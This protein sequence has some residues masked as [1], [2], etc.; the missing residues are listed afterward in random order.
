MGL[1]VYGRKQANWLPLQNP[2]LLCISRRAGVV[3]GRLIPGTSKHHADIWADVL[4]TIER[5]I[6]V[7]GMQWE[8]PLNQLD[9]LGPA[10]WSQITEA[11]QGIREI[12]D[13]TLCDILDQ[14]S[15]IRPDKIAVEAWD[16]NLTYGELHGLS[17]HMATLLIKKGAIQEDR[18]GFSMKKSKWAMVT[19]WAILMAGCTVVPLDIRNPLKRTRELV[20]RTAARYVVADQW[21][22]PGLESVDATII[23]CQTDTLDTI[24]GNETGLDIVWPQV[25]TRSVAYILFTSGSTGIPKGVVLEHGPLYAS[26]VEFAAEYEMSENSTTFQFAPFV[27][28]A[29]TGEIFTTM[30]QGGCL[31]VPSE[32]ERLDNLSGTLRRSRAT[33]IGLPSSIMAQ[34][35]TDDATHLEYL[36]AVGEILSRANFLKWSPRV[37]VV[38]GYGITETIIFDSF[39]RSQHLSSDHRNIGLANGR[40]WITDEDDP[41]KLMP[42]GAIG[43]I[44]IEGP[45]LARGYLDD[46]KRTA[47]RFILAPP[48]LQT[49]RGGVENHRCYRSGDYGIRNADGTVLYMGRMDFQVK[50]GGQRVELGE[51]EHNLLGM[52]PALGQVA[53]EAVQLEHRGNTQAVVA[54]V[55][56]TSTDSKDPSAMLPMDDDLK[57]IFQTAQSKLL[58]IL[59]RHMVPRLFIPIR[60]IPK[61]AVGKRD[62]KCLRSWGAS[63]T[64]EQLAQYQLQDSS[65]YQSPDTPEERLLHELWA[66][67]L[68]APSDSLSLNDNFFQIGGDSIKAIE[69]VAE[70]RKQRRGLTVSHIFQNPVMGEMAELLSLVREDGPG[71]VSRPFDLIP[72]SLTKDIAVQEVVQVCQVN[73]EQI[74]DIYPAAP[75]QEA[76]MAI[77]ASRPTSFYKHRLVFIMPESIDVDRFKEAWE[78]LISAQP[79]LRT[80]IVTMA[81]AGT[82]QVVVRAHV[83]WQSDKSLNELL[84]W[85]DETP[86]TYGSALSRYAIVRDETHRW[87]FIWSG[88]HAITDGWSRPAMFDAVRHIYNHGSVP[89]QTPYTPFIKYIS[90]LN[91]EESDEFWR[92]QF[93]DIV[94]SFPR[95]CSPDFIPHAQHMQALA[96]TLG[97]PATCKTTPATLVQAAWS[98]VT[99]AYA[100]TNEAVFGLTLSG[101]DAPVPDITKMMGIT[102][103]TVPVRVAFD[104][105]STIAEY[106]EEVQSYIS[107]VKQHQH[108]GLQRISHLSPEARS[109]TGFQNLLVIQPADEDE[110]H[111]GLA[112]LGL[113]LIQREEKDKEDHALTIQCTLNKNG[114]SLKVKAYYDD[115]VV[116]TEEVDCLL[117]LFE[118]IVKQLA[119]EST[120]HSLHDFDRLSPHDLNILAKHNSQAPPAIEQTLHSLFEERARETPMGIALDGFGGTMTYSELDL[121]SSKLASH[122]RRHT[123]VTVESRVLL[124]FRKSQLP[125]IA[126][127]AIL[128]CGGV[129]VSTDPGHPTARL[130][131]ISKDVESKI[132]LC[133]ESNVEIFGGGDVPVIGLTDALLGKLVSESAFI[134]SDYPHPKV[135][136]SNAS[137]IVYTS[138]S[139]GKPKGSVLEHR[140]LVTEFIALGQRAGLSARSR[141]LQFSAYTFDVHIVEIF[142]TLIHGGCVCVISDYERMNRLE[143]VINERR[144]NFAVLTKTVSRLLEPHNVPT[145]EALI[146]TGEANRRQDYWRWAER[147]RLFNGLGPSECTPLVCLTRNPVG[148]ETDPANIGNALACRLWVTDHRRPDRL[149]PIGCV[150]ELTVEGPIVG[151]G[152]VN[153]PRETASAFI[154]DPA[155]ARNENGS[156]APRRFYRSGDLAKMNADGSITF[157]GRADDQV[158]VHGQRIELG[159]VEDQLRRCSTIFTSSAVDAL[160]ISSRGGATVLAVFCRR[161]GGEGDGPILPM[162]DDTLVAFSEAQAEVSKVLPRYMVPSVFLPVREL[163]FNASGKLERKKLRSWVADLDAADLGQYYLTGQTSSRAVETENEKLLAALWAKVL[164]IPLNIIHAE[165]NFFRLGG[166]SVLSIKLISEARAVGIFM[167]VA[168]V[169]RAPS[170]DEMALTLVESGQRKGERDQMNSPI[171]PVSLI[172]DKVDP[173]ACIEDAAQSCDVT[174]DMIEDI[175]PCNP[176]QEA[177]MAV[178][179]HRQ[180][181]YTYQI[182]LKLPPSM[183]LDR[184]KSAWE[185]LVAAQAIYRTRIVFRRGLGSLQVVLRAESNIK[186]HTVT[187]TSLEEYLRTDGNLLVE[188]GS[189]LCKFALLQNGDETTFVGTIHHALYDGWSLMLTYEEF[190]SIYKTGSVQKPVIPYARLFRHL[191]AIDEGPMDEFWKTQFR[192]VIESYPWLPSAGYNPRPRQSATSTFALARNIESDFTLATVIQAT[193]GILMSKYSD[194]EAVV[195][196]LTLSGRDTPVDGIEDVIGTTISTVPVR[197]DL[198]PDMSL[199]HIL[200]CMQK[201]TTAIKKY[202]HAGLQRIRRLSP[203]A[204]VAAGF[205]NLLVIQ[206]MGD[207]EITTPLTELGLQTIKSGAEEFL[208][209]ALSVEFTIRPDTLQVLVNYDNAVVPD[210]QVDFMLHQVEHIASTLVNEANMTRQLRDIHLASPYDMAHIKASNSQAALRMRESLLPSLETDDVD[211]S[212]I[213][214]IWIVESSNDERLVPVGCVGRLW[215]EGATLAEAY[216]KGSNVNAALAMQAPAWSCSGQ[217]PF[218][219]EA[220]AFY[221]TNELAYLSHD[222]SVKLL[223]LPD[224]QVKVYGQRVNTDEVEQQIRRQLPPCSEVVVDVVDFG[225]STATLSAFIKLPTFVRCAEDDLSVNDKNQLLSFQ[226]IVEGIEPS[227]PANLP[228]H[229]IPSA[230][231]PVAFIPT[232]PAN[233]VDKVR[234]RDFAAALPED[235]LFPMKSTAVKRQLIKNTV[236]AKLQLVWSQILNHKLSEIRV[237]D[238]FMALGGDSITAMQVVSECRKMGI[239]LRVSTV[240]QKKTI[241]AIAPYCKVQSTTQPIVMSTATDGIEFNLSPAQALYFEQESQNPTSFNQGFLCRIKNGVPVAEIRRAFDIV[242][243]H[244]AMLRARFRRAEEDHGKW[245]QYTA[246]AT[247]ESWRFKSHS[248]SPIEEAG[249]ENIAACIVACTRDSISDLDLTG[250][251]VFAVD[252]FDVA[253]DDNMIYMVAH[254][255]VIDLVS[256]RIIWHDLDDIVKNRDLMH[257]SARPVTFQNWLSLQEKSVNRSSK[258]SAELTY[259]IPIP[260]NGFDFWGVSQ[261]EN[262][263]AN[264]EVGHSFSLSPEITRLLIGEGNQALGTAPLDILIGLLMLSFRQTFGDREIP[265]MFI[266]HHGREPCDGFD[267]ID[268][269]HTV[270]WFTTMYP[271]H[272]PM[273]TSTAPNEAIRLAKDIRSLVPR[274]GQPYF[275]HRHLSPQGSQF[276]HHTPA[277]ILVNFAGLFQQLESSDSLVQQESR[278]KVS[279]QESD[280]VSHRYAMMDVEAGISGG[281]MEFSLNI[282][283]KMSHKQRVKEWITL[284]QDLLTEHLPSLATEEPTYTLS[285]FPR[286]DLSY[287]D[288][289]YLVY[290]QL[291][292]FEYGA[293]QDICPC[294]AMQEGVLLSQQTDSQVYKLEH[295]W[296]FTSDPRLSELDPSRLAQAWKSIVQRHSTLRT[297]I[298]EHVSDQGHFIQVVLKDLPSTRFVEAKEVIND[299]SDI[300]SLP[301]AEEHDFWAHVPELTLYITSNGRSACRLKLSHVLMDGMSLDIFMNEFVS[302]LTGETLE[303]STLAS[304]F[305]RYVKYEENVKSD[306]SLTYWAEYLN[307]AKPCHVPTNKMAG[308]ASNARQDYALIKLPDDTADGLISLSQRL[309]IT[310]AAILQTSWAIVL[311]AF[312]GQEDVCFGYLAS[313]RDA[314]LEGIEQSIGLLI[315]IQ[316]C[317]VRLEGAVKDRMQDVQNAI[318]TGLE[319]RNVSLA[320]IQSMLG[321]KS[322]LLFNSCMSI[323]RALGTTARAN[324]DSLIKVSE[325]VERT[326]VQFLAF[327]FLSFFFMSNMT[328]NH[329]LSCHEPR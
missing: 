178:S 188:Y 163:P 71:D 115:R 16:G 62:R 173:R 147:L 196:G 210:R 106:L 241:A 185:K 36:I 261:E 307:D 57:I 162:D 65:M 148:P 273:T 112:D 263:L 39:A 96:I 203:A 104:S 204:S 61:S 1:K 144:V 236:E 102:I 189:E 230:F 285:D 18:I 74:E 182:V 59:P 121:V 295:I 288:L 43:E 14:Q 318:V 264:G 108:V 131:E 64:E 209:I 291:P 24:E 130:L 81:S 12:G 145:L 5:V 27:F 22:A 157:V 134:E 225:K 313:G 232:S 67:V 40:L 117:H 171:K 176:T 84:R 119:T 137:F 323:R 156:G 11:A 253:G 32:E 99:A 262:T 66:R 164:C 292:Q 17:R 271:V 234:L 73:F 250:G 172:K 326:E 49:L 56:Q 77:S 290:K 8:S 183:D 272:I 254:H 267:E 222:G 218:H 167:T 113:Q 308:K 100:N 110:D 213:G 179:S 7:I 289:Q 238:T 177:L 159:E 199:R 256:W 88:H 165:G 269:S 105:T 229:E 125:I 205:Q 223:G 259:P 103:T 150:G 94:E 93:P 89:Q 221:R 244:H 303:P 169:F 37:N 235:A 26:V 198:E 143:D 277:E 301:D 114:G 13:N 175:Y 48:W 42:I 149:V 139:T 317:R 227:L 193:W 76:L 314:E 293:I 90:Q 231:V 327:I 328:L 287:D 54:F 260:A 302:L 312:T 136:P 107:E 82:M 10:N 85:D 202:Q 25:T 132:V 245:V 174:P 251:P 70:L 282:N 239:R 305:G 195:Y 226:T 142:G 215:I 284:F 58:E 265:T 33:H 186:W 237:N 252:F 211:K 249:Q 41:G 270:G 184:F 50:I 315:S 299:I 324:M 3:T 68:R 200:D 304:D 201:K 55:S 127:L 152:Y 212:S 129:C 133:D 28:D 45:M 47:E 170:L 44:L 122:L 98:L 258:S 294:T 63:L 246:P 69:L 158:K 91:L 79:I 219:Q 206:T 298:V 181:A 194:N 276:A 31:F 101:R 123:A 216:I 268:L 279:I 155:W 141:T 4:D 23:N 51:V 248:L 197:V 233:E 34:V 146:L 124:C 275:A 30:L 46:P 138:G 75:M 280:A 322:S 116:T 120:S 52:Q 281:V 214:R 247:S 166:D 126:M 274:N 220:L 187:G 319:H 2:L 153:R 9:F 300:G 309:G 255:L 29:S 97:R 310:P 161:N 35:Q 168:D 296:E 109:A 224:T 87:N 80:R 15:R 21:T 207:A 83:E 208:D 325:G 111:E 53:V 154:H 240:L 135:Q 283:K 95:L 316:V 306:D 286:L 190:N 86:F 329:E 278:V 128:K 243:R 140:S 38:S 320:V 92:S 297:G 191:S 20:A 266:E 78:M 257:N 72:V 19:V 311:G 160:D 6:L 180:N 217:A 192:S 228:Q 151:R 242:V 60:H 321:L 118:H